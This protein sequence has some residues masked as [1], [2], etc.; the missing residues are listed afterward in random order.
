MIWRENAS[1]SKQVPCT[2]AD[3]YQ[4][5][6]AQPPP[7]WLKSTETLSKGHFLTNLPQNNL[8]NCSLFFFWLN[9][10][11]CF[12]VHS[13]TEMQTLIKYSEMLKVNI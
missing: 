10:L 9:I 6:A 8:F 7:L 2:T 1:Y 5:V 11:I 12:N 3:R 13:E 4:K